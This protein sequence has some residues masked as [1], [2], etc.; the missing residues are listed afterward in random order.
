MRKQPFIL[1]L[2]LLAAIVAEG[3]SPGS[4]LHQRYNNFLAY[5]NTYYNA[6]EKLEEGIRSI[7]QSQQAIDR[8]RL[9][10]VFRRPASS[11]QGTAFEEAIEKASDLLRNRP[12]SKYADEALFLIGKAYFYQQNFVGA[13][14]KFRETLFLEEEEEDGRAIDEASFWLARTLSAAGAYEEG[15]TV[16]RERLSD[17]DVD[18]RWRPRLQLAMGELLAEAGRYEEAVEMLQAGMEHSDDRSE[19]ARAAFLLGQILEELGRFEEAVQAYLT[20]EERHAEYAITYAARL[21]RALVLGLDLERYAEAIE[22]MEEMQNDGKNYE[23]RA[24]VELTYARLLA[25]SGQTE[26]ARS[27]FDAVLYDESLGGSSIRGR[28]HYRLAELHRDVWRDF[29]RAAV[30][31]DTAASALRIPVETSETR[32]TREA[33]LD[34]QEEARRL[35]AYAEA[36]ARLAEV[37]SLLELAYLDDAAFRQRIAEIEAQRRAEYLEE[38][39]RR[40]EL[41]E[42]QRFAGAVA[43]DPTQRGAPQGEVSTEVSEEAGFLGHRSPSTVESG[44]ITFQQTWGSRPLVPN[45]RR[46]AVLSI[47]DI[48]GEGE[49]VVGI[50]QAAAQEGPP[51]LDISNVPRTDAGRAELEERRAE[52]RYELANAL[53]LGLNLPDSARVLYQQIIAETPEAPAAV[54]ARYALAEIARQEDDPDEARRYFRQVADLSDDETL[55]NAAL[56]QLG[57]QAE[58]STAHES[59]ADRAFEGAKRSWDAGNTEQAVQSFVAVADS[60]PDSNEAPRALFAAAAVLTE[61][62]PETAWASVSSTGPDSM[63]IGL[64]SVPVPESMRPEA[65]ID[66]QAVEE[67]GLPER[68]VETPDHIPDKPQPVRVVDPDEA[69]GV[70]DPDSTAQTEHEHIPPVA[71]AM[72]DSLAVPADSAAVDSSVERILHPDSLGL[73]SDA[74]GVVQPDS[75]GL[76]GGVQAPVGIPSDSTQGIATGR[77]ALSMLDRLIEE[78]PQSDA[79]ERAGAVRDLLAERL[80]LAPVDAEEEAVVGATEASG[81]V[82]FGLY[83]EAP[84]P[85]GGEGYTLQILEAPNRGRT[86]FALMRL[87]RE[88]VRAALARRPDEEGYVVIAGH[89]E[90][91]TDAQDSI[92]DVP[93]ENEIVLSQREGPSVISLQ[94]LE[95]VEEEVEIEEPLD[96][97]VIVE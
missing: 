52:R 14:E 4:P 13:E 64:T 88:G 85:S 60:F 82:V 59:R 96:R 30:H 27:R 29:Q 9:V 34:A 5:F 6:E 48:D 69:V 75:I 31:F 87:Q 32:F 49:G 61:E 50:P 66:T 18:S 58:D 25:A 57:E 78:Y 33:M 81:D 74:P 91:E 47:A 67:V 89:F 77:R 93:V 51:P 40:G 92:D 53:F 15:V 11:G 86:R 23:S 97:Q 73:V 71:P 2:I 19:G 1:L 45:W 55:R 35:G 10:S 65:K 12:D 22:L 68:A 56:E 76:A 70:A 20:S 43:E 26:D 3:C 95:I 41:E 84:I 72:G 8:T 17:T 36:A 83:G 21:N 54:R 94:D 39:E 79:T 16:I 80:G 28:V 63:V 37:D 7:E 24:E 42:R 90:T 62:I 44:R 38:R 46:Q